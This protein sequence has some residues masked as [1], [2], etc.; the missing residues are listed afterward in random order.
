[1]CFVYAL[2]LASAASV[3]RAK[4][5][6]EQWTLSSENGLLEFTLVDK[7]TKNLNFYGTKGVTARVWNGS[8]IAP[9]LKVW[10][11]DVLTIRFVNYLNE[12][13]NLHFHGLRIAPKTGVDNVLMQIEPGTVFTYSFEIPVNH[14]RGLFWYHSHMHGMSEGQIMNGMKGM[15]LIQGML[16]PFPALRNVTQNL[17]GLNDFYFFKKDRKSALSL[18]ML[19]DDM[20]SSH[21]T[22]RL[23]SGLKNPTI[24]VRPGE[25]RLFSVAN[26]GP[27]I[28]YNLTL[29]SYSEFYVMAH[30][31]VLQN[32]LTFQTNILIGPSTRFEFLWTA[33]TKP[34]KIELITLK[35]RTGPDGDHFPRVVIATVLVVGVPV[36]E[37]V[38]LPTPGEFPALP[39]LRTY[40]IATTRTVVFNDIINASSPDNGHFTI[41]GKQFNTSRTD[42][43]ATLGTVERWVVYNAAKE[44]HHFHIHQGSFQLETID[45]VPQPFVGQKDTQVLTLNSTYTLLVPFLDPNQV[46]RYVFHCHISAHEDLGMMAVI[47]VVAP[48]PTKAP[49]AKRAG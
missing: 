40:T 12:P 46:G 39:D 2:L 15:L 29:S 4:T 7:L 21:P 8:Y 48:P 47:E 16:E 3:A 18:P 36:T 35:M 33:P 25:T 42:A 30:D 19:T 43:V 37:P 49:I 20:D 10:P 32:Q 31:G 38:A 23:V 34:G 6:D 5:I 1:M 22:T 45:G 9:T 26:I 13:S 24:A 27:D 28:F 41:N 44:Y 17:L 11:G 14:P